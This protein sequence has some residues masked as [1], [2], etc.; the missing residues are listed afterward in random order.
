MTHGITTRCTSDEARFVTTTPTYITCIQIQPYCYDKDQDNGLVI[1]EG[2]MK[3]TIK[4][5]F[6]QEG[7][8]IGIC[9]TGSVHRVIT[10]GYFVQEVVY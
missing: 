5:D 8:Y 3:M 4:Y 2:T 6:V 7:L 1:S 9:T 10:A